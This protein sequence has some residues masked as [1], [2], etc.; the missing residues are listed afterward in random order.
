MD[1][2]ERLARWVSGNVLWAYTQACLLSCG[3][4]LYHCS[5]NLSKEVITVCVRRSEI[6]DDLSSEDAH[7]MGL[8]YDRPGEMGLQHSRLIVSRPVMQYHLD[9]IFSRADEFS[10]L[11]RGS[12]HGNLEAQIRPSTEYI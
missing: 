4:H 8:G 3:I 6:I 11:H 9:I 7:G 1:W 10:I 5:L 2:D 12:R